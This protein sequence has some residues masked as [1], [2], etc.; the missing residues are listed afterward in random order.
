MG[1]VIPVHSETMDSVWNCDTLEKATAFIKSQ[2]GPIVLQ[3]FVSNSSGTA[4]APNYID[5]FEPKTG[6]LFAKIPCTPAEDVE[7]AI[8]AAKAAFPAW[9]KTTRAERSRYL[10]RISDLIQENRE[11]FA[12]WESID[13]GKTVER[14][15]I[16]VD[17]AISNFSYVSWSNRLLLR[18]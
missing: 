13:Q 8:R 17:R 15:R 3:N 10:R 9:S 4:A 18:R 6:Q 7:A 16:E 12:V 1:S 14:A 2:S 5:S 11:L